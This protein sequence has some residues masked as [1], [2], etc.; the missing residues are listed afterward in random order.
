MFRPHNH[1]ATTVCRDCAFQRL[2]ARLSAGQR[3]DQVIFDSIRTAKPAPE[4]RRKPAPVKRRKPKKKPE[5][6]KRPTAWDRILDPVL[7]A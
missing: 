1:I 5:A 6:K 4:R 2:Y 7:Q 3:V